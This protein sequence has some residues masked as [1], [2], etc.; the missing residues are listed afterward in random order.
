MPSSR[1]RTRDPSNGAAADLR[2]RPRGHRNRPS[3]PFLSLILIY[4]S[5]ITYISW[6]VPFPPVSSNI[7]VTVRSYLTELNQLLGICG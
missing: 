7:T 1:I 4:F 6:H 5:P 3:L 2:L